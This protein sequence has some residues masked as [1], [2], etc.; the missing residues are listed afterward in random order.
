M[1]SA[2]PRPQAVSSGGQIGT[3]QQAGQAFGQFVLP[4]RALDAV[5]AKGV[6]FPHLS[7]QPVLQAFM[8]SRVHLRE[9]TR[10]DRGV[11]E[12]FAGEGGQVGDV[13]RAEVGRTEGE[14]E[15]AVQDVHAVG[16]V[17]HLVSVGTLG[18]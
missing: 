5:Q 1:A 13:V 8:K 11:F 9:Q 3:V 2:A 17:G 10:A 14:I 7:G 18:P 4:P 12:H 15:H 16:T 6:F